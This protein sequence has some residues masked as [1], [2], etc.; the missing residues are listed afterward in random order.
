MGHPVDMTKELVMLCSGGLLNGALCAIEIFMCFSWLRILI[1]FD[2]YS[3]PSD[4][5]LS[6]QASGF[7][8]A[9]SL[10]HLKAW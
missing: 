7:G 6:P 3:L 10:L 2:P 1:D 9:A 4:G 8:L 5:L